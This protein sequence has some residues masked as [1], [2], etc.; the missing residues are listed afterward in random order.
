MKTSLVFTC[1]NRP[2]FL[3]ETLDSWANAR[4]FG[5]WEP[6]IFVEPSNKREAV[7][8]LIERSPMKFNIVLNEQQHGVLHNPWVAFETAFQNGADFVILAEDDLIVSTDVVEYFKAALAVLSPAD[9]LTV[10]A[11]SDRHVGDSRK[12]IYADRFGGY[13]WGTWKESWKD[14]L[15]DTWDH[16]YSTN[17]GI[18]MV[19]SGWDWNINRVQPSTGKRFIMPEVSRSRHIGRYGEHTLENTFDLV[20]QSPSFVSK[21]P[22]TSYIFDL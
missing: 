8:R 2:E 16:D 15:R 22:K 12:V 11:Y 7:L 1:N 4:S 10:S 20:A 5:S 9:I 13:I 3:E 21:R 6:W 19:E 17:N 14:Y 18:P